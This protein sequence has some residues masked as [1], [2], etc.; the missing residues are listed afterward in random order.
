MKKGQ[1]IEGYIERV[2][3]PNKGILKTEEGKTVVVKNALCGQKVSVSIQKVRKGKAEGRLL[4]ILEKS[5]KELE[6]PGCV[7]YGVCGG[8]MFQ[9]LPYEEQL[10]MKEAQVKKLIDEVITP[11][12]EDY[13]FL[14]IKPSPR[15]Q[16]YRNKMEFY[17]LCSGVPDRGRGFPNGTERDT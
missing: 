1:I 17:Y 15:Q 5:P 4:E 7:H 3:F 14:P 6:T 12:N 11:E 10:S 13:K 16:G 9:S 2:D 8:C